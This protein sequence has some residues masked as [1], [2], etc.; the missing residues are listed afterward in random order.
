MTSACTELLT[1]MVDKDMKY[2]GAVNLLQARNALTYCTCVEA[3]I[4]ITFCENSLFRKGVK[5]SGREGDLD[6]LSSHQV[7]PMALHTGLIATTALL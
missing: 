4:G 1:V 3:P 7:I 5:R 6:L 2:K